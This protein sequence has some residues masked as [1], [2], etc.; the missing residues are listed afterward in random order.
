MVR[1]KATVFALISLLLFG[2]EGLSQPAQRCFV[3]SLEVSQQP[4]AEFE[5]LRD[6]VMRVLKNR[7]ELFKLT[8]VRMTKEGPQHIVVAWQ[9]EPDLQLV[10]RVV[11]QVGLLEFKRVVQVLPPDQELAIAEDEEILHG[12]ECQS[13]QARCWHYVVK[14]EPLL[15]SAALA[16]AEL[17]RGDHP[18][19]PPYYISLILNDEGA[20]RW[21]EV[22]MQL[23]PEQDRLAIVVDRVVYSAPVIARSLQ[24]AA[25]RTDKINQSVITG[26]FTKDEAKLLTN[27]LNSGVLP[28]EVNIVE[29]GMVRSDLC[30][31]FGDKN[32]FVLMAIAMLFLALVM[33]AFK[34]YL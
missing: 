21:R 33:I 13:D 1:N 20:R 32:F 18:Y 10:S 5:K 19:Q 27:L 17:R 34:A 8:P 31:S 12:F 25:S 29:S 7:F 28:V 26:N 11:H 3:L 14:K 9:R 23:R 30:S 15:T 6:A 2:I 4:S 16:K 22:I 24:E